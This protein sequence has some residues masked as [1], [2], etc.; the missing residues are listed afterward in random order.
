MLRKHLSKKKT[1]KNNCLCL[2]EVQY[3]QKIKSRLLYNSL[4]HLQSQTDMFNFQTKINTHLILYY[5]IPC[6]SE[7]Y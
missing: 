7:S 1:N 4:L 6:S 2:I 5:I 3:L